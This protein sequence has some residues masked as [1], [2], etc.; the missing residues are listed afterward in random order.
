MYNK[1]HKTYYMH[2]QTE[3]KTIRGK[4]GFLKFIENLESQ[5]LFENWSFRD[6]LKI[7]FLEIKCNN[8][9]FRN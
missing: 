8:E 2:H 4:T 1:E 5:R 7:T 6:Y 9:N 3:I